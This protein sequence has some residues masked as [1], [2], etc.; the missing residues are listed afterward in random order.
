MK[1]KK[2]KRKKKR[3]RKKGLDFGAW[4]RA[5]FL[6]KAAFVVAASSSSPYAFK[7]NKTETNDAV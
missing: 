3:K 5:K 1:K 7:L 4:K 2:K 6:A